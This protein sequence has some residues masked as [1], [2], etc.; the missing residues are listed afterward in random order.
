[1][2]LLPLCSSD[3]ENGGEAGQRE[4]LMR[5]CD[6]DADVITCVQINEII[7]CADEAYI[8]LT[9]ARS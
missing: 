6:Q 7:T 3:L 2:V 8:Q 1:M 5:C 4:C 9:S